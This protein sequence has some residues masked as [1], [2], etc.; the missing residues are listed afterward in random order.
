MDYEFYVDITS[1]ILLMSC[2]WKGKTEDLVRIWKNKI[3]FIRVLLGFICN[4]TCFVV[5]CVVNKDMYIEG[6]AAKG[7]FGIIIIHVVI[8]YATEL[9]VVCA[10]CDHTVYRT[11]YF[12]ELSAHYKV[13]D[14]IFDIILIFYS[15]VISDWLLTY[16]TLVV[17]VILCM[18]ILLNLILYIKACCDVYQ[19]EEEAS[20]PLTVA[21]TCCPMCIII[22]LWWAYDED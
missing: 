22:E 7:L 8:M 18:D 3:Y 9:C 11:K 10:P 5:V 1:S 15:I 2:L 6:P 12:L 13:N 19:T 16:A 14:I 20:M 21:A 17:T 4:M